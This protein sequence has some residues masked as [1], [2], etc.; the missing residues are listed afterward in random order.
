[1][2]DRGGVGGPLHH[3]PWNALSRT[4][5]SLVVK[6]NVPCTVRRVMSRITKGQTSGRGV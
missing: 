1:M 4:S 5:D 6:L 2:I 3:G